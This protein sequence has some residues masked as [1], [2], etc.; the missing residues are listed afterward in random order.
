[1]AEGGLTSL[2][3][4]DYMFDEHTFAGGGI[5]A[6]APG[7]SINDRVAALQKKAATARTM[8]ERQQY[9]QAANALMEGQGTGDI[10]GGLGSA[11][12]YY[13]AEI[14]TEPAPVQ[15]ENPMAPPP[16][17]KAATPLM[18]PPGQGGLT[19]AP[20]VPAPRTNIA[21]IIRSAAAAKSIPTPTARPDLPTD[22]AATPAKK[23]ETLEDMQA[24]VKKLYGDVPT[25]DKTSAEDKAARKK[26]DFWSA[27]AQA[28]FGMMAGTSQNALTNIGEG[29][30]AAMPTMQASLKER[31]ADEKEERAQAFAAK[32][33]AHTDNVSSANAAYTMYYNANKDK[34]AAL[35]KQLDREVQTRGQ[36]INERV[37]MAQVNKRS[38]EDNAQNIILAG[39]GPNATPAQQAAAKALNEYRAAGA[40]MTG[41]NTQANNYAV[42][43]IKIDERFDASIKRATLAKD[44]AKAAQLTRDNRAA[45]DVLN[46]LY[47]DAADRLGTPTN[48]IRLNAQGIP[49]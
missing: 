18:S 11:M 21:D 23:E 41:G 28:G 8:A 19:K 46:L 17:Q 26:E 13:T 36:D 37:G 44:T 47:P 5:V 49:E 29:L 42:Q 25:P 45:M 33:A 22:A 1:M 20:V 15:P 14:P 39:A 32:I 48:R 31:R 7:G 16:A 10:V 24:R 43:K 12:D 27:M 2:P 34:Q 40:M 35:E 9:L 6:F 3:V 30:K 38:A 4:P